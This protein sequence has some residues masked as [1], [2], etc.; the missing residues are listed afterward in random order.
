MP[1][2]KLHKPN[3]DM[4]K[5]KTRVGMPKTRYANP[6]SESN[7][8][9]QMSKSPATQSPKQFESPKNIT[10]R[11]EGGDR[12]QSRSKSKMFKNIPNN[13]NKQRMNF[14]ESKARKNK[15]KTTHIKIK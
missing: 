3:S 14:R 8:K 1:K 5:S 13:E 15:N 12:V 9:S 11:R 7:K 4:Q 2:N 10:T 6:S